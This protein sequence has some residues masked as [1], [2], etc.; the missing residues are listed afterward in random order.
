VN[1]EIDT[2]PVLLPPGAKTTDNERYGVVEFICAAPDCDR[3]LRKLNPDEPSWAT[4]DGLS[5]DAFIEST[6]GKSVGLVVDKSMI[7]DVT[8]DN[9]EF[10]VVHQNYVVGVVKE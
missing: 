8:I 7:E 6:R 1:D 4:H 9:K 2:S 3:F 10:H 5:D